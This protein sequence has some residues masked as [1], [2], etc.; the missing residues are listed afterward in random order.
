MWALEELASREEQERLCLSDGSSGEVSSFTEAICGVF[1]NGGV[2][3]AL[4]SNGLPIE[5]AIRFKELSNY[6][7]KVPQDA[8]P[9]EQIGHPAMLEITRL[10]S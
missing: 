3:R 10:S 6:I 5:L 8:P 1:D 4:D 2:S 7:D 9:Q